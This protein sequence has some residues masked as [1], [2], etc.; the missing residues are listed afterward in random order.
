MGD[1]DEP[2]AKQIDINHYTVNPPLQWGGNSGEIEETATNQHSMR[3]DLVLEI[4]SKIL[5]DTGVEFVRINMPL[6]PSPTP[7][8]VNFSPIPSPRFSRI[9]KS[10][11]SS[12]SKYKSTIN[13]LLPKLS[14][15]Y[16]NTSSDIEKAAILALGGSFEIQPK[17]QFSRTSSLKK[18]FTPRMKSSTSLPVTPISHSNPESM[19]GVIST[20]PLSSAKGGPQLP[21]HRSRSVPLL[22]KDGSS[23]QLDSSGGV[24]RVIPTTT[25]VHEGNITT[26]ISM[27]PTNDTDGNDNSHDDIP[28]EEAVCRICLE[29][30]G[31]GADTLKMECSCKGELALAHQKCAIKW[32]SIKGNK[33]CD[34]CK[35]EVQNLPV[36]LLRVQNVQGL[37]LRGISG[38]RSEVAQYRFWQDV[39]ILVIVSML[40][41]FCFLEQLLVKK[42][43]TSAISVSLPFSCILGLLA[44]MTSS[45]MVRRKYVWIFAAFQFGLVV[46]SAHLF[47]SLVHMQAILAILLSTFVGFGVTICG[48]SLL[49]EVLEW[50]R[51]RLA[52]PN[53]QHGSQEVAQP[54]QPV[55]APESRSDP[56]AVQG[57]GVS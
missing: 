11:G 39:P 53:E 33:T 55:T 5:D 35:K 3:P 37:N 43:G 6:T 41:Y 29:E 30:L 28:E 54:Q 52:R 14:F 38:Q 31:E 50:R 23:R 16:R 49:A 1:D 22:N 9:N 18:I 4:P 56:D 26:T 7:K 34:V 2:V 20:D 42:M 45:T 44:S 10:Q 8:R 15:K 19:H 36:T 51:S 40:A 21:I 57:T 32:F 17:H 48:T 46:V 25:Q 27:V 12:S 13:S 47:Y 24:F